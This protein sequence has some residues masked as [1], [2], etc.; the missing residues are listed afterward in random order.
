MTGGTGWV[1]LGMEHDVNCR[2]DNGSR[3]NS[4]IANAD[5]LGGNGGAHFREI[6]G[7]IGTNPTHDDYSEE[8]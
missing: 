1:S 3:E 4:R 5:Y 7:R 2:P 8:S 6:D